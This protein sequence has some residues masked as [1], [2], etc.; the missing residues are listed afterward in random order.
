MA[1][2][3]NK[4]AKEI[5]IYSKENP[6]QIPRNSKGDRSLNSTDSGISYK[7]TEKIC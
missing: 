7:A 6:E 5:Y 2:L 1:E 3:P 4:L